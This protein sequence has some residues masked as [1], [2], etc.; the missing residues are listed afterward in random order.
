MPLVQW[1]MQNLT[2][3]AG[4]VEI[5]G[6]ALVKKL[7]TQIGSGGVEISGTA[8]EILIKAGKGVLIDGLVQ[9]D[10]TYNVT[11]SGGVELSGDAFNEV[12]AILR[13][14][15][16]YMPG[17]QVYTTAGCSPYFVQSYYYD[18]DDRIKY[19]I[20]NG[21]ECKFVYDYDLTRSCESVL[22]D[23]AN[24]ADNMINLLSQ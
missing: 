23:M 7:V 12:V 21:L 15:I 24:E 5:D 11:T 3:P 6:V 8:S 22:I 18:I 14:R 10:S 1:I 9:V 2:I 16:N 4:G 17:D 13:K 19:E 20:C